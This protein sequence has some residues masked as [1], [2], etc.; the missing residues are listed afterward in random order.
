LY[1]TGFEYTE[2]D[3]EF[4]ARRQFIR[5]ELQ[6][7]FRHIVRCQAGLHVYYLSSG[8]ALD[9]EMKRNN[10]STRVFMIGREEF[11]AGVKRNNSG[12]TQTMQEWWNLSAV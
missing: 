2:Y 7:L 11:A 4:P 8:V 12:R 6:D 5:I 1:D 9:P 3:S 10:L